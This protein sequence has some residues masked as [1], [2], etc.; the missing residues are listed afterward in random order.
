[1]SKPS[2]TVFM[3]REEYEALHSMTK[4]QALYTLIDNMLKENAVL[5][6][7]LTLAKQA[8]EDCWDLINQ[9]RQDA[10]IKKVPR[11]V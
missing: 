11:N 7:D 9:Y 5:I 1:M 4:A 2:G 8:I 3:S 6:N 10:A